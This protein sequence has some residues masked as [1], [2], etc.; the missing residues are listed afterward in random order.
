MPHSHYCEKARWAL[1]RS[2]IAYVEE[3]HVPLFHRRATRPEG[4]GSVPVLVHEGNTYTDSRDILLHL[5]NLGTGLFPADAQLRT[6]VVDMAKDFDENLGPHTRRW[7]YWHLLPYSSLLRQIMSCGV[8]PTERILLPVILPYVKRLIRSRL[9]ITAAG[10]ARSTERIREVF[11]RVETRLG[12]GRLFLV[13][14]TLTAADITFASLAAPVLFPSG[15][16]SALPALEVLPPAVRTE[17]GTFRNSAAGAFAL[18][19]FAEHR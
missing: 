13:G 19:L 18:R 5:D 8:P 3:A 7:A 12:D 14:N 17:V 15:Y 11:T 16:R 1:D 6:D 4:G 9:K 2:G 10:A